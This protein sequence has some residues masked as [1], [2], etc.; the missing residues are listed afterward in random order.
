MVKRDE[1]SQNVTWG[2][3][4]WVMQIG[5][6]VHIYI[7]EN[8]TAIN[9]FENLDNLNIRYVYTNIAMWLEDLD[10]P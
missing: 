6:L 2:Y 8:G 5:H 9:N 1:F 4:W 7:D 3:V 10:H